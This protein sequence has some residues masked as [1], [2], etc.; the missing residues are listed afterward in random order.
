MGDFKIKPIRNQETRNT[1][2]QNILRDLEAF[3]LML[4]E[5]MIE[6]RGDRIGAEQEICIVDK[7]GNPTPSALKILKDL[8]QKEYTNELALFNLEA[9]LDP[10]KFSGDCF[11]AMERKLESLID[12]GQQSANKQEVNLFLTGILP[13]INYRHLQFSN[14]TPEPRYQELS[15]ELLRLRGSSFEIYLQGVDDLNS[16]LDSVLFEACNTSFQMHLQIPPNEFVQK[17]NW[18]QMISGPVLAACTNSPFI[19]GKELW[20]E[21]R[22]ALFKQ[23]LD[24]RSQKNYS[25][26]ILPRVYFGHNWIRNSPSEIWGK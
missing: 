8:D 21:S 22:I 18:A 2:Y 5:G 17:F 9:N 25:R 19:F 1:V 12:L 3:K 16:T 23:S 26:T 7:L 24:I 13:S 11:S 15:Q 14:M 4:K 20:A 6:S 10:M